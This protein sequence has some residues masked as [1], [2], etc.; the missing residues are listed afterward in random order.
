MYRFNP[1]MERYL[2]EDLGCKQLINAGNWKTADTI[3][4][5]DVERW[6]YTANEVLAVNNYYSPVHIGPDR[7]WRDRQG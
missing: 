3:R 6:S 1:E 7:G 2:R 4:L 5:N